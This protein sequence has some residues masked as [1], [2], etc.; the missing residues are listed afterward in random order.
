MTGRSTRLAALATRL[1]LTEDA[2]LA[3]FQLDALAAIAGDFEHLPE[4]EVL[5]GL[6]AE[7]AE[8]AG[9]GP[10]ARWVHSSATQPTPLELLT[11]R[12][13]V[14]FEDALDGWLRDSGVIHG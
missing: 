1:D 10:L 6:T 11:Q 9:D 14:A 3:I 13:F 4:I 12:D 5:D 2:V 7:A 8:L